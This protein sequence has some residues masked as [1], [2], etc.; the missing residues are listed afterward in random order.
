MITLFLFLI[1][2]FYAASNYHS[3]VLVPAYHAVENSNKY[4]KAG[5][6]VDSDS[7]IVKNRLSLYSP[8]LALPTLTHSDDVEGYASVVGNFA[9][10]KDNSKWLYGDYALF[11]PVYS[12]INSNFPL[13]TISFGQ[14]DDAFRMI[15]LLNDL[16][17]KG[18]SEIDIDGVCLGFLRTINILFALGHSHEYPGAEQFFAAAGIDRI[19]REK[20]LAAIRSMTFNAPLKNPADFVRAICVDPIANGLSKFFFDKLLNV[21]NINSQVIPY[22]KALTTLSD[23]Q[24]KPL[25]YIKDNLALALFHMIVVPYTSYDITYPEVNFMMGK[26]SHYRVDYPKLSALFLMK[27]T[28]QVVGDYDSQSKFFQSVPV[29]DDQ[30]IIIPSCLQGNQLGVDVMQRAAVLA[31]HKKNGGSY[32]DIK[33][34][35]QLGEEVVNF[36]LETQKNPLYFTLYQEAMRNK[37]FY[38]FVK[39]SVEQ[40]KKDVFF[41]KEIEQCIDCC[42]DK[43]DTLKKACL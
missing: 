9:K 23:F 19:D 41:D 12:E 11:N 3:S 39:R 13:K 42:I 37:V 38:D 40:P 24:K 4:F 34:Y 5:L 28:D 1:F 25:N 14:G 27:N 33:S 6:F 43:S 36:A 29:N 10:I 22:C 26:M 35:L 8:G 15:L 2:N 7:M 17:K 16:V 30:K 20:M 31:W 21:Y 18:L 32:A